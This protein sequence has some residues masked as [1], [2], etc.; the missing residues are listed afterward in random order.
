MP[1]VKAAVAV[2][3]KRITIFGVH[4]PPPI[5]NYLYADRNLSLQKV[6]DLSVQFGGYLVVVGDLN[7]TPWSQHFRDLLDEGE[8]KDGRAGHGILPTWPAGFLPLQIPIDHILVGS[9]LN[10]VSL[11][12]SNGLKSDHRTIWG[13]IEF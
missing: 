4:P 3:D 9:N 2:G 8:L 5:S 13:D 12:T 1:S 10:V 6:A 11:Q 7:V